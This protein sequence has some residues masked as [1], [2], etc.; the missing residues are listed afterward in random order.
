LRDENC[1]IRV[2]IRVCL[3]LS[4]HVI[5]LYSFANDSLQITRLGIE[6][7]L[8]NNSVRCIYQDHNGF[9]WFGTYDGLNRYNG[10]DFKIFRNSLDDTNSLPHNFIYA[11]HEDA[12]YNLWVGTGQGAGIYNNLTSQFRPAWYLRSDNKKRERI[13]SNVNAF[14]A[15]KEG[16]VFI[17]TNGSGLM[18]HYRG[19]DAACQFT[20]LKDG[21]LTTNYNVTSIKVDKKNRVWMFI[22][23]VGLCLFDTKL[24]KIT[25]V[26]G[27]L[28]RA[29]CIEVDE[30]DN[31]WIGSAFGL[32]KYKIPEASLQLVHCESQHNIISDN[33][34]SLRLGSDGQLWIG[35]KGGGVTVA[36]L[37]THAVQYLLPGESRNSISSEYIAAIYE[38]HEGRKWLGTIKGG[39]NIY[40]SAHSFFNTV[41]HEKFN[42]NSLINNFVSAF[43]EDNSHKVWVGTDGGGLS[44]WDRSTNRFTNYKHEAGKPGSLSN[45]LISSIIQDHQG[46]IWVATWGGGINKFNK[47]AGTFQQFICKNSIT[48]NENENV[49]ILYEDKQKILW[50]TT[51][52]NGHLYYLNRSTNRFEAFSHENLKDLLSFFQDSDGTLWGG[53]S[54][55]LIRIDRNG[56]QHTWYDIGKPVRA[57]YESKAGQFWLGTEGGG[58][59]LF[60]RQKGKLVKRFSV[61]DGLANNAV[62][63]ILEDNKG[64][65]W[66]SSFNGLSQLNLKENRFK[67]YFQEDGLQS[68]QFLYS[69]A[70]KLKS[71]EIM[72]GGIRGFNIF[73]PGIVPETRKAA[74]LLITDMRINNFPLSLESNYIKAV[75]KGQIK[76][77][78]I[79]FNEAA[80]SVDFAA[81]EFSV[82]NKI[83]YAYYLE[84][85]DKSWNYS[86]KIRTA[87]YTR[88]REG[89]YTL[90]IRSTNAEGAWS[91]KLVAINVIVL[92]PWYRS[93]WSFILYAIGIISVVFSYQRHRVNKARLTYE[94]ALAKA[95]VSKEKA[96]RE[97]IEAEYKTQLAERETEKIKDEKEQEI[98]EKRLTFFTSI[99]HEFRTPI[100]LII[101][102]IKDLLH[103]TDVRKKD[104][105]VLNLIYRNARRLLS[106]VDQ[107]LLFRK[108]EVGA[109]RLRIVKLDLCAL[110][111]EV[112]LAFEHQARASNIQ[113]EFTCTANAI[114]VYA[115][116]E[117]LEIA[118]YNL[119]SNAL[120]YTAGGG[121]ILVEVSEATNTAMALVK[122]TGCGIPH[123]VADKLF[124]RFYQVQKKNTPVKSGFG[125]G[126]F[127]VKHFVE[128]LKGRIWYESQEGEGT[129]F[130]IEL[131]KGRQHFDDELIFDDVATGPTIFK[132]LMEDKPMRGETHGDKTGKRELDSLVFERRS[133]LIVDDDEQIR[134]YLA[135]L[136]SAEYTVHHTDNAIEGLK[137][138]GQHVPDIIIS[139]VNMDGMNGIEFCTAMKEDTSLSH[140][141]IILLTGN[142]AQEARLEGLEGGA[143]DYITKPFDNDLL[144]ARVKNILKSRTT[145]QKYFFNEVTLGKTSYR[146]APEYKGFLDNCIAIVEAHLDNSDFGI[147]MLAA[148]LSMGQSNLYKKVKSISGQSPS[149]FIR[150]IRLRK[151]AK[152]LIETD[153][154]INIA[155]LTAGFND[156]KYFREQFFRLFGMKPSDFLKTF[157][158]GGKSA[159]SDGEENV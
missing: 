157:R 47:A 68:N 36:D 142:E 71:G 51:F 103:D 114:E 50:A 87:N 10:Y 113:Y 159:I 79:P 92:P 39:I 84:G 85:W 14:A 121:K 35:S 158:K 151:V 77:I 43:L 13:L 8:S 23:P 59:I 38:D 104:Q 17:G 115:D 73:S 78:E 34:T 120:K 88:L 24:K 126:L 29:S 97:K 127:L 90:R 31:V 6:K 107:L 15:D 28:S 110:C 106:L 21:A 4:M 105:P 48:G 19:T 136:F 141:P 75:E 7:G 119:I 155:A 32:Y 95:T 49:W 1:L 116:R 61:K 72:F 98:N 25:K 20:I 146:V 83:S 46:D 131:L 63:N 74:P 133:M 132:E 137:L 86:G 140:I 37:T 66:M 109:D 124:E 139:D 134:D 22:A 89:K 129:T 40:S 80:L 117:K 122:D 144:M 18:V 60:D 42:N 153:Y 30:A 149:S 99:S 26:N 56:H 67:N 128:S 3:L 11:I 64:D 27:Q 143:D 118:F 45:N 154:N 100:G 41:T 16:N 2:I 65:L 96:E 55:E 112:F 148:E 12:D 82:P 9:M 130:F 81:L 69:A 44:I 111:K 123:E 53:N 138:A 52:A 76:A 57:I 135:Q 102:P 150:C 147:K 108:A 54:H 156:M 91:N 93:W 58:L 62:L 152:L 125:I 33:I 5:C 145:L 101:N 94:V 70:L